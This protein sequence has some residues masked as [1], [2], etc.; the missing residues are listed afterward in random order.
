[1][2]PC[3]QETPTVASRLWWL[4]WKDVVVE[5]RS[6]RVWPGMLLFGVVVALAFSFQLELLERQK[7]ELAGGLVWLATFF[8]GMLAVDRSFGVEREESCLEA[9]FLYPLPAPLVFFSKLTVNALSLLVLQCVLVPLTVVLCQVSL[10]HRPGALLVVA[11]LS[12]L[13]LAAVGTLVS[14][15]AAGARAAGSLLALLVLPLALPVLLASTEATRL[16]AEGRVGP[17]WFRWV[18]L[19]AVFAVLFVTVGAALFPYAVEE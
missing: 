17:E 14:A 2:R 9:L 5:W 18:Q 19:L 4:V 7:Q 12:D 13:G 16:L 3:L 11:L 8:A 6:R 10:L 1:M 15:L